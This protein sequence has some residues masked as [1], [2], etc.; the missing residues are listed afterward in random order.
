M[1]NSLY[2]LLAFLLL[3]SPAFATVVINSPSNGGSYSSAVPFSASATTNTCSSGVAAMGV[4]VNNTLK[5]TV[6]GTSLNT[7]V[8]L[9]PGTYNAVVEEWDYCGGATTAGLT[10]NV[11]NSSGV[12]VSSPA[13]GATVGSPTSFVASATTGCASGIASM[14]V[15]DNNNLMYVVQGSQM[16]TQITLPSGNQYVVVEE[17]DHCGGAATKTMNLN[18]NGGKMVS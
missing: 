5:Y 10:I 4:Y 7:T 6:N 14:G 11:S 1:K 8:G 12:S 16:N 2:A 17:W 3:T 9:T 13:S 18:V 15:Y